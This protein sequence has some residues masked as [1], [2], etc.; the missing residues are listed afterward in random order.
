MCSPAPTTTYY[1]PVP[2]PAPA[3]IDGHSTAQWKEASAFHECHAKQLTVQVHELRASMHEAVRAESESRINNES[4]MAKDAR[5][6]QALTRKTAIT[7]K[8]QLEATMQ[9]QLLQASEASRASLQLRLDKAN[10]NNLELEKSCL[11]LLNTVSE[12]EKEITDA[13][14]QLSQQD[15]WASQDVHSSNEQWEDL[16]LQKLKLKRA[17]PAK[18]SK[19][20]KM[21]KVRSAPKGA[22]VENGTPPGDAHGHPPFLQQDRYLFA[23]P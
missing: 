20:R 5:I 18:K 1:A 16:Q 13:Q 15:S 21:K 11:E 19:S 10:A 8:L 2:A 4:L 9:T 23:F 7:Q 22:S 14:L 17:S 12:K 3:L 6:Q